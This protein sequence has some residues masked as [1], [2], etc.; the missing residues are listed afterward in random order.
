MSSKTKIYLPLIISVS[1][2][3]GYFLA[4]YVNPWQHYAQFEGSAAN[5]GKFEQVKNLIQNDY[6]DSV[7]TY[8][9][10]EIAIISMLDSLDPH[11][12]YISVK[13][14][15]AA[16][17]AIRGD[18][19][20]I[21]VQ[22]RIESDT[23]F[24]VNTITGG[25]SE[26]VGLQAGDRIVKVDDS[27]VAGIGITNDKVQK[28]LKGP[29]GTK[30]KVG[31]KRRGFDE[32][33]DYEI[34]RN[35]IPNNSVEAAYIIKDDI[36]YIKI[37]S[38]T[39]KTGD[40]F[41]EALKVLKSTGMQQLILDLRNNGG[42][43]L[44]CAIDVATEFLGKGTLI[45]YS[46]GEHSVRHDFYSMQKGDFE[47]GNL[48]VLVD[49]TSASAS[50]IVAGAIQ[51][52][53]RGTIMGRRTFG[54]GLVQQQTTLVDKS[55]VRLTVSRYHTPSGRCIQRP[56]NSGKNEYINNFYERYTSGELQYADSIHVSDTTQKYFTK[57]GR[58][59]YGG[60]G[61]IPDI[62]IP[63]ETF[64]DNTFYYN[65]INKS[66]LYRYAFDYTDMNRAN[67]K[68]Q[69]I[70]SRT[71][72]DNFVVDD[73]MLN[74]IISKSEEKNITFNKKEFDVVEEEIRILVKAYIGR[75]LF[76]NLGFYPIYNQIDN[77]VLKAVEQLEALE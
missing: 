19:E 65:L 11:S 67:L 40:E 36:G 15:E 21:G 74:E 75:N 51:D 9:L 41:S 53:D 56:Y 54:K 61:I 22:F 38:F 7:N 29:K 48:V 62:F 57:Q 72:I 5:N 35:V 60:G 77:D 2:I 49:E 6:V 3:I 44:K 42:G 68:Q 24:V 47:T 28:L 59:V 13:E 76:D 64:K 63:I 50:E 58:I 8:H 23:I 25:P 34:V 31:I 66:I 12:S 20:G 71:F 43:V 18:F 10:E 17:E 39:V 33:L 46:E 4:Q 14:L 1:V 37:S 27:I 55:A 32:T 26:K 73:A 45:M 70:S 69:Y 52:N 16:N 30:V